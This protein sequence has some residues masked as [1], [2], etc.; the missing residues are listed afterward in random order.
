M[1]IHTELFSNLSGLGLGLI[2]IFWVSASSA[3]LLF[4]A[5]ALAS[6]PA[7]LVNIPGYFCV[8]GRL[9]GVSKL[10]AGCRNLAFSL[11][12]SSGGGDLDPVNIEVG[13]RSRSRC[14]S[15][16]RSSMTSHGPTGS[17]NGQ[18]V[19]T[20][21]QKERP[22]LGEKDACWRIGDVE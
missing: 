5:S 4:L 20:V 6:C 11:H 15:P 16:P 13:E 12:T 21:G 1:L 10:P 14:R 3:A 2:K 18:C 9:Q 19:C 22:Q 17:G 8:P 7:G